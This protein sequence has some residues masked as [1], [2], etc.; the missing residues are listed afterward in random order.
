MGRFRSSREIGP[1][2]LTLTSTLDYTILSKFNLAIDVLSRT[3][4]MSADCGRSMAV[5]RWH[6]AWNQQISPSVTPP[7]KLTTTTTT[8]SALTAQALL[9]CCEL[10]AS[11]YSPC[12]LQVGVH[13]CRPTCPA[14]S[15][16]AVERSFN[17]RHR[18]V[19]KLHYTLT[20]NSMY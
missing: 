15:P 14:N 19:A 3:T 12:R 7:T 20:V 2:A 17:I 8:S 18:I 5:Y 16:P 11:L 1:L 6:T 13:A 4:A 10:T 9:D